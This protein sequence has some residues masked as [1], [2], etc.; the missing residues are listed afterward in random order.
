M[1]LL[2]INAMWWR[3]ECK[4]YYNATSE[5]FSLKNTTATKHQSVA[6]LMPPCDNYT[7]TN[8]TNNLCLN[9]IFSFILIIAMYRFKK[10]KMYWKKEDREKC[11]DLRLGQKQS[12]WLTNESTDWI[13]IFYCLFFH[14]VSH[15]LYRD[16]Q[17]H[18]H[19]LKWAYYWYNTLDYFWLLV[20]LSQTFLLK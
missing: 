19:C 9:F 5:G 14:R 10:R 3:S 6:S 8:N 1:I 7:F 11:T 13:I 16:T 2:Y 4:E 20:R 15:I 18:I 12:N 17:I